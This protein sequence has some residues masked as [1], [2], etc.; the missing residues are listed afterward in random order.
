MKKII[1]AI[2]III[3]LLLAGYFIYQ[4]YTAQQKPVACT[5]EAK[6]CPDGSAVGRTGPNCE[7][8]SCPIS[9]ALNYKNDEY[10]F[11]IT[12]TDLWKGYTVSQTSWQG[13]D[14]SGG[15]KKYSGV[16][17]IFN[18]PQGSNTPTASSGACWQNIPIMVFTPDVWQLVSDEKIAV[19]AAPIGPEKIGENAKYVFALP[20]RWYGFACDLGIKDAQNIVKT[21][22]AF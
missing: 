21:F 2:I 17:L 19:S 12:F 7:F 11:Q 3:V 6:I 14:I 20:P 4:S 8:A 18:N 5:M 1:T 9:T 16:E 13:Q 10:G 22:K 15:S